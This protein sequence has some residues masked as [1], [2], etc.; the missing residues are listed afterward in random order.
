[1]SSLDERAE[2]LLRG[3]NFAH[4]ATIA[5]DGTPH[6]SPVWVDVE[7]GRPVLNTALGRL[8]ERH[9]R[10]DPRITI[11]VQDSAD[12]YVYVEIRGTAELSVVGAE[13]HIDA[14]AKKYLGLDEYPDKSPD[15]TR[16]KV[17][18]TPRKVTGLLD[19]DDQS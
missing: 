4:V 5:A 17:Y 1:M 18:V 11:A 10:R 16:V 9:L 7:D 2:R 13:E 6:V 14:L 19:A 8:K 3:P 12:P 15:E